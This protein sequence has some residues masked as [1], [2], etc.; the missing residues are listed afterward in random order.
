MKKPF[1]KK[2][3][4]WGIVIFFILGIAGTRDKK[5]SEHKVRSPESQQ[6]AKQVEKNDTSNNEVQN[7]KTIGRRIEKQ[8]EVKVEK[9]TVDEYKNRINQ[10]FKEME[11]KQI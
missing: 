4:F 7:K 9:T 11:E 6:A 3:W 5:N 2:W 10:A 8:I 1:Y